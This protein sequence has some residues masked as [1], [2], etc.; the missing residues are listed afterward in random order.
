MDENAI[1]IIYNNF[2]DFPSLSKIKFKNWNRTDLNLHSLR[3]AEIKNFLEN[4]VP[5]LGLRV[6]QFLV[7]DDEPMT[8]ESK[9]PYLYF[10]NRTIQTESDIGLCKEHLQT[11]LSVLLGTKF[12]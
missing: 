12:G 1:E 9:E 4:K 2:K 11:A 5:K 10:V 3:A 6:Q 8:F 7:I